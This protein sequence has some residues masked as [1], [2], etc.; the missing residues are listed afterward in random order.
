MIEYTLLPLYDPIL[1]LESFM[2]KTQADRFRSALQNATEAGW[3]AYQGCLVSNNCTT[4]C[5]PDLDDATPAVT[6][7]CAPEGSVDASAP[8]PLSAAAMS[9]E[10]PAR[11]PLVDSSM[12]LTTSVQLLQ[13]RAEGGWGQGGQ[14][15]PAGGAPGR[16]ACGMTVR[17]R[18]R[19]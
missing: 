15:R 8:A 7:T 12:P 10:L 11:M 19:G 3:A 14:A 2:S 4:Y 16:R 5:Q 1:P 18:G 17:P 6:Y 13:V 9:R